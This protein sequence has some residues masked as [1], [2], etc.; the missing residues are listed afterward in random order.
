MAAG[1][2]LF[3]L[4]LAVNAAADFLINRFGGKGR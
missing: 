3:L 2:I 4:T 1:L